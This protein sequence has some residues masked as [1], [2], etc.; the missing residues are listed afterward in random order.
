LTGLPTKPG[1]AGCLQM[2]QAAVRRAQLSSLQWVLVLEDDCLLTPAFSLERLAEIARFAR[3][4]GYGVVHGGSVLAFNPRKVAPGLLAVDRACSAHFMLYLESGYRAV[5][6]AEQPFD[7]SIADKGIKPLLTIPFMAIQ[8]KGLSGI[9]RPL[10][11]GASKT[12]TGPEVVDYE[13][14][15]K[16]QERQLAESFQ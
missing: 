16:N 6:E 7:L 9:G 11:A 13:G 8:R 2:H 1:E 5:L 15:F 14:L 4:N 3:T 10:E 12:Y